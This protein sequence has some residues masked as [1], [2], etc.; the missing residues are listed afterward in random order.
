MVAY[1]LSSEREHPV[2]V[3]VREQVPEPVPRDAI[4]LH[5]DYEA[6]CWRVTEDGHLEYGRELQPGRSTVAGFFVRGGIELA[7]HFTVA[8]TIEEVRLVDETA[9]TT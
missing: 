3:R 2:L 6:D 1:V 5:S 9:L 7:Q 8:P 4:R